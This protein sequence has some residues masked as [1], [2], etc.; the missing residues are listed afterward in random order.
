M[1]LGFG[2][3]EAEGGGNHGGNWEGRGSRGMFLLRIGRLG[4][5][6]WIGRGKRGRKRGGTD[7]RESEFFPRTRGSQ[8]CE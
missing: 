2:E 5:L 6:R 7:G 8:Q 3:G 1:D 4:S